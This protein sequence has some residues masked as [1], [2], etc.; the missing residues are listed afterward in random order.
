MFMFHLGCSMFEYASILSQSLATGAGCSYHVSSSWDV[1]S[2]AGSWANR[3]STPQAWTSESYIYIY[4]Y[5]LNCNMRGHAW[6]EKATFE[7]K[8][9]WLNWL[10]CIC[11]HGLGALKIWKQ[12][13]WWHRIYDQCWCRFCKSLARKCQHYVSIFVFRSNWGK[14]KWTGGKQVDSTQARQPT[15]TFTTQA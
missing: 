3:Q 4:I 5:S 13:Q 14:D 2:W 9:T 11:L 1:Q 15:Q 8:S 7:G 12:L 10:N 6:L